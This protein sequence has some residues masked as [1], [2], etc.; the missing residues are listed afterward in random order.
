MQEDSPSKAAVQMAGREQLTTSSNE[1]VAALLRKQLTDPDASVPQPNTMPTELKEEK[2]DMDIP[3][4][5]E[6]ET[7]SGPAVPAGTLNYE[8]QYQCSPFNDFMA[9]DIQS[10]T[11][12]YRAAI[13]AKDK[14]RNTNDEEEVE[15]PDDVRLGDPG[16]KE[17]Y[18]K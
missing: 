2:S 7:K 10:S 14:P 11:A 6:A 17:R 12:A 5:S 9:G 13:D 1:D 4:S 18:Y 8:V 16:W 15:I 3:P